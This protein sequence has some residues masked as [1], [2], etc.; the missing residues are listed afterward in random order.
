MAPFTF[1]FLSNYKIG[2]AALLD[3]R[4][5]LQDYLDTLIDIT[6]GAGL[7]F[8][9]PMASWILSKMGI[10]TPAFLR[11][12]RKYAYIALLIIAAIITPSPDWGSQMVV[13]LPLILLYEL[14]IFISARVVKKE[15][16][17]WE[18]WS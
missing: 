15:E 1:N 9:L 6:L 12:Y 14:S 5:T 18:E 13:V 16:K 4:P 3:Y 2:T 7:A 17:K 10:V 8:E 11:N